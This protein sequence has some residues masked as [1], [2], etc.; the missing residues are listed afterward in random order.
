MNL[1]QQYYHMILSEQ[2]E[3]EDLELWT[4]QSNLEMI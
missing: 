2:Q 4:E 3:Q 1:D